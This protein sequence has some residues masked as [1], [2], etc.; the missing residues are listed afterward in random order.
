MTTEKTSMTIILTTINDIC[1]I[2][3]LCLIL[4]FLYCFIVFQLTASLECTAYH[5]DTREGPHC[6]DQ[7]LRSLWRSAVC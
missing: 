3:T 7:L 4:G 5:R 1:R 2:L 6:A